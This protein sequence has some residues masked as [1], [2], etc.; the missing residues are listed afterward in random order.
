MKRLLS[1]VGALFLML[2]L[3]IGGF[4]AYAMHRGEELDSS[5]KAYVE[6]NVPAIA[7][8]WSKP[9]LL[10]R[11]SS[12]LLRVIRSHPGRIDRMFRRLSLLGPMQ[13][14]GH[15]QGES[16]VSYHLPDGRSITAVYAARAVFAHG[17]ADIK[18]RLILQAGKW[19]F[20]N[21]YVTAPA[22]LKGQAREQTV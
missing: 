18:V 21:F 1:L 20:L 6:A 9:A 19:R 12:Q 13:G 3:A 22:F 16:N 7:S 4:A 17:E 10:K 15:V 5:S 8:T 2:V 11:A 14:F